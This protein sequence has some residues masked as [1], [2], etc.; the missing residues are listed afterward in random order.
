MKSQTKAQTL[1][2]PRKFILRPYRRIPTWFMSYYMSGD[3]VGK[4]VVTNL[5]CTG[6]RMLGDHALKPGTDLAVRLTLEDEKPPIELTRVIVR[7]VNEYDFGLQI[8]SMSPAAAKR[9]AAVLNNQIRAGR[10]N[11]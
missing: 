2:K 4:G 3:V 7:W 5:S 8:D 6:M 9:I 11:S 1:P 10:T